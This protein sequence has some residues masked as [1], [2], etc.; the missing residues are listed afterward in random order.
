LF[1]VGIGLRW[2]LRVR[3]GEVRLPRLDRVDASIVA[4]CI[5]SSVLPLGM[6]LVRQRPI[7]SDDL[8]YSIVMWKLLAEYVIV[9]SAISTR[10]QAMRCLVLLMAATAIVCIIGIFQ[11]VG[12]AGI[13]GLLNK[14]TSAGGVAVAEGGDRGGSLVGLP[15]A[16]ADLAIL[17]LGIAVAMLARGYPRRL[18]LGGLA[19]LYALG[20]VAAAEF[21]TVIGLVVAVVALMV[22]TRSVRLAAYAMPVALLGGV[23]LWPIIQTRVQGFHSAAGLPLSWV[24]RLINLRTF[25][26]PVLFSDHNWIL[27]VRPAARV[28]TPLRAAGYVWIES[29]YTWLLWGGGIP[30]FASYIAF[31]CS[32]IQKGWA[33][34]RRADAAGIAA[35]AVTAAMCSQVILMLFDPHLTYRG[36]GDALFWL[37]ALIRVLP[38][39]RKPA[40]PVNQPEAAAV[41]APQLQ[42]VPA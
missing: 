9:R 2:L 5:T 22:L 36:S 11:A 30:L 1:G 41:T 7:S 39:R 40:S 38:A 17:N 3:S 23:L 32:V 28:A 10:E 31:A 20:V 4:L 26:W 35:T 37:L 12:L 6:M 13:P 14:Y 21:A 15:A 16:A 42:G 25:F 29:G 18:L 24:Y 19:V 27:G 8:L 34:A 33:H